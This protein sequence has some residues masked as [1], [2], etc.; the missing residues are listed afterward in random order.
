[1]T[2]P[3]NP[4]WLAYCAAQGRTDA[5]QLAH[6]RVQYPGGCMAGFLCWMS[7]RRV[8]FRR[9]FGLSLDD[10]ISAWGPSQ[11]M[12]EFDRFIGVET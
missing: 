4:R 6:D 5:E 3:K 9:R 2:S 11:A 7:E 8:A 1:M 12:A 10:A